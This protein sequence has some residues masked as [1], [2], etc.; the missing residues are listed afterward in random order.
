MQLCY[1]TEAQHCWC[2]DSSGLDHHHHTSLVLDYH[3]VR[4]YNLK[5][6]ICITIYVTWRE[7]LKMWKLLFIPLIMASM[8]VVVK[9]P[10]IFGLFSKDPNIPKGTI[11][12]C[13]NYWNKLIFIIKL[14]ELSTIGMLAGILGVSIL[15]G[16]ANIAISATGSSVSNGLL[17]FYSG[18]AR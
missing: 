18:F 7:P 15:G 6:W 9:P 14:S 10:M 13:L 4:S 1:A 16:L 12:E 2:R 5:L 8:I 11:F 3:K 17:I